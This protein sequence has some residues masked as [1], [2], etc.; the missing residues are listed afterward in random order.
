MPQYPSTTRRYTYLAVTVLATIVLYDEL[1]VQNAVATQVI[2]HFNMSFTEFVYVS[3]I[4]NLVGAF[5]SLA[6]GL[7]DRW[8]RANLVVVGLFITAAIILLVLPNAGSSAVYFIFFAILSVVE[9]VML[10]ATPAL[11]RDFSPQLGRAGAMAFWTMGPVLGSLTVT[12]VSSHT[13]ES[14]P[15]WEFQ[16]YVCG[17]VGFVVAVLALVMLREL[18]PRLR[19]QLMVSLK[20]RAVLEA[21]ARHLDLTE[22]QNKP[23]KQMLKLDVAGSALG[24]SLFLVFYCI[25]VGFLVVYFGTIFGYSEAK[26][27]ALANWYWISNIVGLLVCGYLS[28][29]LAVRK[30]FMLVGAIGSIIGPT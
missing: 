8:G 5:G 20:D 22:L 14:H 12:E 27:N 29:K 26:S 4:G 28:D 21:R 15:D 19:D 7:A 11:I 10:V 17:V 30:P 13:L 6:A 2:E 25:A 3:V 24:I 23:W 9:G 16:F 18:H 1:Y